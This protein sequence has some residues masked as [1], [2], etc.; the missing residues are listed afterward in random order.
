MQQLPESIWDTGKEDEIKN[1][2]IFKRFM[3][4]TND[5]LEDLWDTMVEMEDDIQKAMIMIKESTAK[6]ERISTEIEL[7]KGIQK[8]VLPNVFPA[9]PEDKRFDIYASMTPAKE[10]G[11]DFYDYFKI[12]EDRVGIVIADVSDKGVLASLFMVKSRTVISLRSKR[13][14]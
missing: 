9:F 4:T 6:E 14:S 13:G 7:A 10:V 12:D 1:T 8:A 11:G 5:E 3:I 2:K